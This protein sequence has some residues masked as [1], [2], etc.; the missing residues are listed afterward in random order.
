MMSQSHPGLIKRST[1]KTNIQLLCLTLIAKTRRFLG[2]SCLWYL[3]RSE[4][5]GSRY[6]TLLVVVAAPTAAAAWGAAP[7]AVEVAGVDGVGRAPRPAGRRIL[8]P[9]HC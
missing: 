1:Q 9:V 6:T 7:S 5:L 4:V 3:Q 8:T 2:S